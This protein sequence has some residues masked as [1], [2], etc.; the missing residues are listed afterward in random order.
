M[1]VALDKREKRWLRFFLGGM[2][3]TALS[4]SV[5]LALTFIFAYQ[6]SYFI[7]YAL[8]VVF[9][10]LI[11]ALWVFRVQLSW[12]GLF[13]YPIVYVI[14]YLLSAL[15][16]GVL[17]E[18]FAVSVKLAPIFVIVALFPITYLISRF[19]LQPDAKIKEM[20]F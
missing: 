9:A 14:Q 1:K 16:L 4:Y 5:F 7:A 13:S 17:V 20:R 10:Y 12:K 19:I 3:N 8:G 11:N 2:L 6:L 18:I 15:L